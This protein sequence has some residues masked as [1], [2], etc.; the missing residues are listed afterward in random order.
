MTLSSLCMPSECGIPA[1]FQ[2]FCLIPF[3][4]CLP[5]GWPHLLHQGQ[6]SPPRAL[7]LGGERKV[8][9][10]QPKG[11]ERQRKAGDGPEFALGCCTPPSGSPEPQFIFTGLA[12]PT[13]GL[14]SEPFLAWPLPMLTCTGSRDGKMAKHVVRIRPALWWSCWAC[15]SSLFL[16]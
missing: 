7:S 16:L 4:I 13:P 10:L 2:L 8:A 9:R 12:P 14:S 1:P 11:R 5:V 6:R 15:L 3:L